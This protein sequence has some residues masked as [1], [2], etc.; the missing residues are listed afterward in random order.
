M[1]LRKIDYSRVD[2]AMLAIGLGVVLIGAAV[3]GFF[4]TVLGSV[5]VTERIAGVNIVFHP[6]F[7]PHLRTYTMALW[8]LALFVWS[9]PRL[10]RAVGN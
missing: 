3:I 2:E 9:L 10:G 8:F 7:G 5:H 4:E 1:T 6:S